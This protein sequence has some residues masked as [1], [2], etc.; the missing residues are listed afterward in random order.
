MPRT[1]RP[2]K[3]IEQKRAEGSL[4]AR[5]KQT[6][7]LVGGRGRPEAALLVTE[8]Q[9]ERFEAL[10]A[11]LAEAGYLDQADRGILE[12]AAIEEANVVACNL[13]VFDA[14]IV[15]EGPSGGLARN[16]ALTSRDASIKSLRQIYAELGIGPSARARLRNLGIK[17]SDAKTLI[18]GMDEVARK[19]E[20]LRAASE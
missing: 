11:E 6:P 3:P 1:G 9:R 19:R 8:G 4:R 15:V 20:A 7:L 18:P 13:A 5:D 2:P 12:L 17:P 10:C 16:P 14:G